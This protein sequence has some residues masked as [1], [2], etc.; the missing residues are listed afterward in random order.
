[1]R[2]IDLRWKYKYGKCQHINST[3]VLRLESS[4]KDESRKRKREKDW[5]LGSSII[6]R[7]GI[8]IREGPE[9]EW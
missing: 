6:K 1:M 9:K 8:R 3:E 5:A 7:L 2:K 4:P